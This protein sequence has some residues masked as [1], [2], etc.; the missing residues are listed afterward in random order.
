MKTETKPI[1]TVLAAPR[2]GAMWPEQGG[3]YAGILRGE[4][5]EPDYHL[6][7]AEQEHEI[8]KANWKAAVESAKTAL[9]GFA[10][11]S[12]PNR[13]E[14]RLLAINSPDNFDKDDWHW[15]SRQDADNP[16]YAWLQ[17]FEDYLH[18]SYECRARSVRRISIIK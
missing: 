13:R 12:L 8:V 17:D 15:T 6:I 2:I 18:K 4:N 3:I 1:N 10:D 16:V 5:H 11:W 14:A 9:N 7:H